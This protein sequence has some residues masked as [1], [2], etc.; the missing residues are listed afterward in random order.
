[1]ATETMPSTMRELL[2]SLVGKRIVI[3]IEEGDDVTTYEGGL[4]HVGEDYIII[5]NL[6]YDQDDND[7]V[8]DWIFPM[9]HVS[10]VGS[11]KKLV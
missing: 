5:R 4:R 6:E 1:M 2:S 8:R 3:A 7:D 11:K 9:S 10:A